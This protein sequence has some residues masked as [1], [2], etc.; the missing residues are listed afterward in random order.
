MHRLKTVATLLKAHGPL[1]GRRWGERV[2]A[3]IGRP[4]VSGVPPSSCGARAR[5][6][7]LGLLQCCW[8]APDWI[9]DW[10]VFSP[11]HLRHCSDIRSIQELRMRCAVA[12][13]DASHGSALRDD[14]PAVSPGDAVEAGARSADSSSHRASRRMRA[15]RERLT[16]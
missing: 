7:L 12:H 16:R 8:R 6:M 4:G 1:V 11:T 10:C 3:A 2:G 14:C 15:Q 9:W 13:H 5:C